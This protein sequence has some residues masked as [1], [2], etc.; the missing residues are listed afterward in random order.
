VTNSLGLLLNANGSIECSMR[1][2][3]EIKRAK[4]TYIIFLIIACGFSTVHASEIDNNECGVGFGYAFLPDESD[5]YSVEAFF[6]HY[7]KQNIGIEFSS[8]Y[9]PGETFR[10]KAVFGD[11][12]PPIVIRNEFKSYSVPLRFGVIYSPQRKRNFGISLVAGA[13]M[14]ISHSSSRLLDEPPAEFSYLF[15]EHS[16]TES[17]LELFYVGATGE[18]GFTERLLLIPRATIS[19]VGEGGFGLIVAG[20]GIA[21]RF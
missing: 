6:R 9:I 8:M 11:V 3:I 1:T 15:P 16:F 18:Y 17:T 14:V 4:Q 19:Y 20:A 13:G 7:F 21:Y 12:D 5:S 2:L 10:G